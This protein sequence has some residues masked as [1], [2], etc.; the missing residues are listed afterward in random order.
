MER[1]GTGQ[2][3]T[4]QP[5]TGQT[6]TAQPGTAQPGTGQPGTGDAA[7]AGA[8]GPRVAQFTALRPL[9]FSVAYRMLGT[10]SE[11]DDVLQEAWLRYAGAGP[12]RE[13]R[14]YLVQVVTRLCLDLLDSAR[15]RRER[16]VGPWLPEP[17]LTGA[18]AIGA[19][20]PADPFAAVERRE[21]LSLGALTMLEQLSP[22][23]R[24]VLVLREG[25]GYSHAEVAAAVGI[26]AA[27]SRQLL[28]RARRRLPDGPARQAAD[29]AEHRRLLDA[30]V[31]AFS[32]GDTATLVRLLR[33]EVSLLSDGGGEVKAA[34]RP[35]VGR[36]KV[37]RLL[38]A[39]W[40]Q[41]P[42]GADLVVVELNGLPGI[43]AYLGGVPLYALA[44]DLDGGR[45][46]RLMLVAA[47]SKL[48]RLGRP[49]RPDGAPP[50]G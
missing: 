50:A 48:G 24:A 45:V 13:P 6:G 31:A 43:V 3:G 2:P 20:A 12:I 44:A 9:L 27:S 17:V 46:A 37:I 1:S 10:A 35:V 4:A 30:L 14:P 41:I 39:L 5:G 28:A 21:R 36:D 11:V 23:E 7:G 38:L 33:A 42:P 25:L 22:A 34:L 47:P 32:A 29:P 8:G 16:Y 49:G 19:G 15:V 40:P 26:S 18:S